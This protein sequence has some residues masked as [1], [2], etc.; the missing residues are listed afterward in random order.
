MSKIIKL[1]ALTGALLTSQAVFAKEALF[2]KALIDKSN[3][4]ELVFF[5]DKNKW[6]LQEIYDNGYE[7]KI[8][9]DYQHGNFKMM[10]LI[11]VK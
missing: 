7:V 4:N 8:A 10:R 5:C 2:C 1:V 3:E 9:Y 6:T 11:I